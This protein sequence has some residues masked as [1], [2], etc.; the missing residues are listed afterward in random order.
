M[1]VKLAKN[2]K[3]LYKYFSNQIKIKSKTLE[4]SLKIKIKFHMQKKINFL[5]HI[6]CQNQGCIINV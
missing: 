5:I 6:D 3:Q 1:R 4:L 2:C